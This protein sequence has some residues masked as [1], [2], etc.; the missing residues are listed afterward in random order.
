MLWS[1]F[2]FTLD[3]ICCLLYFPVKRPSTVGFT[4]VTC[5][6]C[7]LLLFCGQVSYKLFFI[8]NGLAKVPNLFFVDSLLVGTFIL[9]SFSHSNIVGRMRQMSEQN[10]HPSARHFLV[11]CDTFFCQNC[12][13]LVF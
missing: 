3:L 2:I 9:G 4:S 10:T 5:W 11:S 1:T 13:L 7:I 6:T 8:L 12:R